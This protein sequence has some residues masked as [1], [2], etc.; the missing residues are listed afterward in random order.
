MI[1]FTESRLEGS[2]ISENGGQKI[3]C[4]VV[5]QILHCTWPNQFVEHFQIDSKTL[6]GVAKPEILGCPTNDGMITW[7]TGNRWIKPGNC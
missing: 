1:E 6:R 2:W 7:N 5:N 4:E 3:N